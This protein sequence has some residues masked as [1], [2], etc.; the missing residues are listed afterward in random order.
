[1]SRVRAGAY[2]KSFFTSEDL[3]PLVADLWP[4]F[5]TAKTRFASSEMS[6]AE[7]TAQFL[8]GIWRSARP[9]RWHNGQRPRPESE[10]TVVL[11]PA[12][13]ILQTKR[14]RGIPP[15][16]IDVLLKWHHEVLPLDL[17]FKIPSAQEVIEAQC[18]GRRCV[19]VLIESPEQFLAGGEDRDSFSFALHDLIHASHFY[20]DPEHFERQVFFSKW[21]LI[22]SQQTQT[23]FH[24]SQD[25]EFAGA[26]EYLVAD[27][28]T[29]WVH[30][31]KC[32][33][34]I[35]RGQAAIEAECL[36]SLLSMLGT[37]PPENL[38]RAWSQLNSP[39]EAEVLHHEWDR[40]L[41]ICSR[42]SRLNSKEIKG[43]VQS[44]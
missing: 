21:M 34:S 24:W 12:L 9:V 6:A 40:L 1:M 16:A 7:L 14:L 35:V 30:S 41:Q 4:D 37:E 18:R 33:K 25:P 5:E 38:A 44:S 36:D 19:S 23:R 8:L 2:K 20:R 31:V 27:M 3:A 28:N 11:S 13:E 17:T 43:Q 10:H 22:F 32:L 39:F 42:H 29:H 26:L 15:E